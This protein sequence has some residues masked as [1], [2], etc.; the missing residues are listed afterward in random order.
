MAHVHSALVKSDE[1]FNLK[2]REHAIISHYL[3]SQAE[4]IKEDPI[5]TLKQTHNIARTT[6]F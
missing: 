6:G 5:E 2:P 4:V 3:T 1:A